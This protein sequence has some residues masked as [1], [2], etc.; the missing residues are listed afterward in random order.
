MNRTFEKICISL[1]L[2]I[3]FSGA[4]Q[5]PLHLSLT[6]VDIQ[7]HIIKISIKVFANDIQ[8][9][10]A[11]N[12]EVTYIV[13]HF[14]LAVNG[15]PMNISFADSTSDY[16]AKWYNFTCT[17]NED[18]KQIAIENKLLLNAFEDQTNL[19]I[20]N[21]NNS[22]KGFSLNYRERNLTFEY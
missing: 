17:S 8:T 4:T 5:H 21:N 9:A 7:N 6:T 10:K 16:E 3:T 18:V 14:N 1:L 13:S 22:T 12:D 11:A 19:V 20:I 15:K 2:I